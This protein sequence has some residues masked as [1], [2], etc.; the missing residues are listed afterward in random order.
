M[1]TFMAT[2]AARNPDAIA[3]PGK[4]RIRLTVNGVERQ[5]EV[6]PWTTLLDALREHL[7]LTGTKKGCDHGQCGACTVLRRRAAHQLV[8]DA[9]RDEGRL[10][11]HHHR[12]PGHERR[13]A[14]AAGRRSSSTTRFQCGYCTSGQICSAAGL[15]AE[16]QGEDRRRGARADER[17]PLPLRRLSEHRRRRS[18]RSCDGSA[19]HDPFRLRPRER[20]RRRGRGAS[21]RGAAR[22]VHRRRHQPGR[23]DEA[24]DVE[25]P[26]RLIDITQLP[27]DGGRG[28]AGRRPAD[29]RARAEQRSRGSPASSSALPAARRARSSP[30][31]RSSCATWRRPAAICCSGR[32]ARTSTTPR[33]RATSAQPGSGCSAIDGVNRQHAILGASEPASP[34]IRRT[35]ASRCAALDAIVHVRGTSRRTSHPVRATSTACPANTPQLDTNLQP[36]EMIT[37]I[38]A[39]AQGFAAHHAYLKLRDRAS[40]AF[41]LVSVAAA[42]ELDGGTIRRSAG[43]TR[44][45]R[46]QAMA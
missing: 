38:D 24:A 45:G 15:L 9:R 2:I 21:T 35:C 1:E 25:R 42:L 31:P 8:P 34:R 13:A 14:P 36:G 6:A 46:A 39:A 19:A 5:L 12:G 20:H 32:A 16:G 23:P 28:D 11:D 22:E 40:Y 44:R 4:L 33:R 27:L 26:T 41:A 37:A 29:R 3:P 43:R 17:Q 30:A 10:R 7:D 18:C